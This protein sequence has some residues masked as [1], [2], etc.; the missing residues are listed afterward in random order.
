MTDD[1]TEA[2]RGL[3]DDLKVLADVGGMRSDIRNLSTNLTRY[4]E[5]YEKR[6]ADHE[7]RLRLQQEHHSIVAGSVSSLV[8]RE[9]DRERRAANQWKAIWGVIAG[10]A[11]VVGE[12]LLG[13][14]SKVSS[15]MHGN[16]G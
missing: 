8:E 5:D 2:I 1:V 7:A 11:V 4:H 14:L 9:A 13:L 15:V 3:R 12:W 16:H 6:L 10:L